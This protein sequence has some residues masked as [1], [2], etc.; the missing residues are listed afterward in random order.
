MAI[1]SAPFSN[2]IS[3]E[4]PGPIDLGKVST[5]VM[6]IMLM[7]QFCQQSLKAHGPLVCLFTNIFQQFFTSDGHVC[8]MIW[9]S[10]SSMCKSS[11]MKCMA[12]TI[13]SISQTD[14]N[15]VFLNKTIEPST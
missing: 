9:R 4:V 8:A 15:Q 5:K 1:F 10:K 13:Q 2:A 14:D 11:A 3:S 12:L 7:Q 6:E